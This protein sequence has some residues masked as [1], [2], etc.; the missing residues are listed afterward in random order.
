MREA[1]LPTKARAHQHPPLEAFIWWL[2]NPPKVSALRGKE[3]GPTGPSC[4]V[5]LLTACPSGPPRLPLT[6]PCRISTAKGNMQAPLKSSDFSKSIVGTGGQEGLY[7][8]PH[9]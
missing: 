6:K 5:G 2:S 8:K 7:I 3:T 4:A 1:R 9:T